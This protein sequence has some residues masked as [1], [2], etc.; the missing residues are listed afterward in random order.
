MASER[1]VAYKPTPAGEGRYCWINKPDT[2]FN[3]QGVYK[4]ELGLTGEIAQQFKAEIDAVCEAAFEEETREVLAKDKKKWG[5]YRPY[6]EEEDAAGNKTGKIWFSF[7]QNA[8]IMVEGEPKEIKIGIYDA[9]D[10]KVTV[11]VFSGSTLR[12]MYKPRNV[13]V[14]SQ[15]LAGARLDFLK[16]QVVKLADRDQSGG[17]GEVEGGY[18]QDV[19]DKD[20]GSFEGGGG[21]KAGDF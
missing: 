2:K 16:V 6:Q 21:G 17:F 7:R 9:E 1:K 20:P 15:K 10:K 11:P 5:I 4:T 3:E 18:V 12:V 14:A 19:T 13:K 8:V